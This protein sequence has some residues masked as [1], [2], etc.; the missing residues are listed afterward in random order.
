MQHHAEGAVQRAV[1]AGERKGLRANGSRP[2]SNCFV[3]C[4]LLIV[5]V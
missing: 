2:T 5:Q 3:D 4:A 1:V